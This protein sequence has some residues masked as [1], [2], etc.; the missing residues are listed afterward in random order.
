[1]KKTSFN[2]KKLLIL[3]L[4][5][6]VTLL[7]I[8]FTM[9]ALAAESTDNVW[10]FGPE[11]VKDPLYV[12]NYFTELPRAFEAELNIPSGSY[13][14]SSPII[15]NWPNYDTRDAFGFQI[16]R[17]GKPSIYYYSTSYDVANAKTVTQKDMAS[18]NYNVY[19]KGW[20]RLSVVNEIVDGNPIYKLYVNGELTDTIT[21][22]TVVHDFD[23]AYSQ[24]H[25]RELSIGND[26]KHYFKGELRNVAVYKDA[27]TLSDA[28]LTAKQ[29][30]QNENTNLM[31]YYDVTMSGNTADFIKDQTGNGHNVAKAFF[32]REE[33]LKDYAYS[34]AFIGDIQFLVEKDVNENTTQYTSPIYDWIIANKDDKNIQHVFGLG[35]ITDNNADKEWEYAVTLHEK[36]G[37]AGVDYSIIPGNHDDYTTPAKKYNDYFGKV[38]SFV[39]SIDGYYID[40]R[41][42]NY[43]TKFD[44]GEHKY[45]VI[46]LQY[47][48]PDEVLDWANRVVL[49]NHDR[50]VIV[51]TH[52]L[53][54]MEGNWALPDT[55]AQTTTS[56][57]Y[58]N[59]GI[60]IWNKFISLHENIIFAS[61]GH[62]TAN[63][64]HPKEYVG[65]NGN[66]VNT[67][68]IDPQGVDMSTGYDTGFVAM[69]YLSE[70]GS[71]VQVE[72]VSATK[73]MRAREAAKQE[74]KD[75]D[76][77]TDILFHKNS[78]YTFTIDFNEAEVQQTQYGE[79]PLSYY[80]SEYKFAIFS[81]GKVKGGYKTWK[82]ATQ[83]IDDLLSADTNA[84]IQLLL[85]D[86]FDNSGDSLVINA[87]NH[88]NGNLVIDLNGYTFTVN[89]TFL[90]F[91]NYYDID[92]YSP[93]NIV[94]KNGSV[95]AGN[96]AIIANQITNKDYEYEKTWNLTLDNVT[97]GYAPNFTGSR[98]AFY[99]AFK[100]SATAD[101]SQLG[102]KTNITFNNCTF[103][104]KTN[105]PDADITLFKLADEVNKM[106]VSVKINGGK[107]LADIA[108]L[109]RVT[110]YT[111]NDGTDTDSIAFGA[112]GS[113][114][115]TKLVTH[116]TEKDYA[117]YSNPLPAT[118]GD[119]YFVEISDNG[120]QSV[121]ELRKITA[122]LSYEYKLLNGTVIN[123]SFDEPKY[124]SELDYPG[125]FDSE[126]YPFLLFDQ[127]GKYYKAYTKFL[128]NGEALG[129]AVYNVVNHNTLSSGDTA[130]ILM[131]S[132]YTLGSSERFD[133]TSHAR[134]HVVIDMQGY[135]IISDSSRAIESIFDSTIK[136]YN[137]NDGIS[138]FASSYTVRNGSFKIH[139][140]YVIKFKAS[141]SVDGIVDKHM[142]WTFDNVSFGLAAGSALNGFFHVKT[143]D[144]STYTGDNA[145][146]MPPL[147]LN[148]NDCTFDLKSVVPTKSPF[149]VIKCNFAEG[150]RI[151]ATVKINGGIILAN[152]LNKLDL[153]NFIYKFEATLTYGPGSDGKY[154]AVVLNDGSS[155]N[156]FNNE[157]I[158][159]EDGTEYIFVKVSE[160]TADG[161]VL[162]R[163]RPTAVAD[164]EYAP[165]M[166]ITLG[167]ELV[168]NV[169]IPVNYTQEFTFDGVI[170]NIAN[171]FD[172]NVVKLDDGNDYYVVAV[173]LESCEAARAVRLVASVKVNSTS[174]TA[175][176]TFSI[177]MYAT[178][179]I[180]NANVTDIEKTLI[181]DVLTY[182]KASYI[183]FESAD[184]EA[185]TKTIDGIL[186]EYSK[187]F[188]TVEGASNIG[189]ALWG[190]E[191]VLEEKPII[192]FVLPEG[193]T[194]DGYT[195]KIGSTVLDFTTGTMLIED[196]TYNYAEVSLYAYQMIKE[197]TYTNGT[198]SGSYHINSYYDF[199]T[200]NE[201]LKNDTNL[202]ALVEKLYNYCK[203]AE[204][205]RASVTSK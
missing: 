132:D 182:I 200:T 157:T 52:S 70:D 32:E 82:S 42:E 41:L 89:A 92:N 156:T 153:E 161:T 162:Y 5:L 185:V 57:K 179:V 167:N 55:A 18:F 103:D 68:L 166:S 158:K 204:I 99:E 17:D 58:L 170:Y 186:G 194:V 125:V 33:E 130:Y 188:E 122:K 159:N 110:F 50:R 160:N 72:C 43:Y 191:I 97:F 108:A 168:M 45:M 203:S 85:L 26:G 79:L 48:A 177:P 114:E 105:V 16:N 71:E 93:S 112:N 151:L 40:G 201:E 3:S 39:N 140:S 1:M 87:F 83:A 81:G 198:E 145:A 118:D 192:R 164:I 14:G 141:N 9:P 24:E 21:S 34:F 13:S 139:S 146:P 184:A 28:A 144:K 47:G 6:V 54:D 127:T 197:I 136:N 106:D 8:G 152:N 180:A 116:T 15:A 51:I 121:Y 77:V 90:N 163:L 49:E 178:K 137:S 154:L 117:H 67:L 101:E 123:V 75:P 98:P 29:H 187:V 205:Y 100:N 195:F 183:Y 134:G 84:D 12:Q 23:A 63:I 102:S 46:G 115:F 59:N 129:S 190:V 62:I 36:L 38:S 7:S 135:T 174:A 66:I 61:A 142:S 149:Y 165:K 175:S 65:A 120:T 196:K 109:S 113:S 10:T 171:G 74:G 126:K 155:I 202:I 124:L 88:A 30:M 69:F 20:I 64:Y 131:R 181:K 148:F 4:V 96:R 199:V 78:Q 31:A 80:S 111:L 73:T 44:V 35:D 189:N 104:L 138:Y 172:G 107:I 193:V 25:T 173:S 53:F 169:Y 143:A 2:S 86:D 95:L 94:V 76:T 147:D 11:S 150:G 119:R 19:G 37:A 91:N 133:N 176:Y 56:R 22:F 27:L 128:G 60:D